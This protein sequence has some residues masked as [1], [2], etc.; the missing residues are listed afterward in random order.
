[1]HVCKLWL[2][3]YNAYSLDKSGS[4]AKGDK[5]PKPL[6][7]KPHD[8]YCKLLVY[9][10][11]FTK[12]LY[13]LLS[14]IMLTMHIH[15]AWSV[16]VCVRVWMCTML[17]PFDILSAGLLLGERYTVWGELAITCNMPQTIRGTMLPST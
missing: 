15:V 6:K 9:L 4:P 1:M 2:E 5:S 17:L 12:C 8:D 14:I 3:K 13:V 16:C 7:D 11:C 10:V